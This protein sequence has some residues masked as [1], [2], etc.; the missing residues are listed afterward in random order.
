MLEYVVTARANCLNFH[1]RDLELKQVCLGARSFGAT[2][3]HEHSAAEDWR[4]ECTRHG[5]HAL[6]AELV[7]RHIR[8]VAE[9]AEELSLASTQIFFASTATHFQKI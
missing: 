1:L 7:V 3:W 5:L 9:H 6:S 2:D 4:V 8:R